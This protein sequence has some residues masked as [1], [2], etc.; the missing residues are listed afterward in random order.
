M[1]QQI[2]IQN[3]TDLHHRIMKLNN[4]KEEQ[5]LVIKRN[6]R[7]LVYSMHPS[8]M[9]KNLLNKLG[10]DK[11]TTSDLKTAGLNLGKDFLI[12]KIFGRGG[13][14]RGFISSLL[15]RKA[16]DYV[17]TNHPDLISNGINK[18]QGLFKNL[19]QKKAISSN[20]SI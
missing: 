18:V 3:D 16:T 20:N 2:V 17:M 7:E 9:V 13:S 12:S 19:K 8:M 4:L 14:V 5:E 6:V 15:V 10:G 11:E 1:S